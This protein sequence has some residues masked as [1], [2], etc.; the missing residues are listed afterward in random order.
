MVW[1]MCHLCTDSYGFVKDTYPSEIE[2]EDI[3]ALAIS[4]GKP[5][6]KAACLTPSQ[7]LLVTGEGVEV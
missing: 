5:L 4:L 6:I 7:W 2:S 1:F 3:E